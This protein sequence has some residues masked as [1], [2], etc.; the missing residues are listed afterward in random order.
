MR[1]LLCFLA[2]TDLLYGVCIVTQVILYDES[3]NAY[4][5]HFQGPY[6]SKNTTGSDM[7]T[8]GSYKNTTG[9][10][11]KTTGSYMK[12][13]GSYETLED[14]L[15]GPDNHLRWYSNVVGIIRQSTVK[16]NVTLV[17][18][19][20][21][22]RMFLTL[23]PLQSMRQVCK[24]TTMKTYLFLTVTVFSFSILLNKNVYTISG[25]SRCYGLLVCETSRP[26]S[27]STSSVLRA[28]FSLITCTLILAMIMVTWKLA[29]QKMRE[30]D[31]MLQ[32]SNKRDSKNFKSV[33]VSLGISLVFLVS[34]S[35]PI[36]NNAVKLVCGMSRGHSSL[37]TSLQTAYQV[38]DVAEQWLIPLMT[39]LNCVV[40]AAANKAVRKFSIHY[41]KL[42]F[43]P[44]WEGCQYGD[45][46][47]ELCSVSYTTVQEDVKIRRTRRHPGYAKTNWKDVL[48]REFANTSL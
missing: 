35:G 41:Y 24:L 5:A 1:P 48:R 25:V 33:K 43:Q 45:Q 20:T 18:L 34:N 3:K 16:A 31:A 26:V 22:V 8:T 6:Q 38:G 10:Y 37:V 46:K 29:L 47:P 7:K 17:L 28:T 36:V 11:M 14:F 42:S 13:T 27:C 44:V 4:Y 19:I 32:L 30:A 12:T 21:L 15:L 9:S 40:Y 2:N 23:F 39:V